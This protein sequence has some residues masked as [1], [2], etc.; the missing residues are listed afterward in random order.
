M[1]I[2][3]EMHRKR[4]YDGF[5]KLSWCFIITKSRFNPRLWRY[6][7]CVI[8]TWCEVIAV[9]WTRKEPEPSRHPRSISPKV[10]T[11]SP[12]ISGGRAQ[13]P[14]WCRHHG[15]ARTNSSPWEVCKPFQ[16]SIRC[17]F[18][19][20]RKVL[21][22]WNSTL[23]LVYLFNRYPASRYPCFRDAEQVTKSV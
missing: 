22:W 23:W 15:P 6:R 17:I 12:L 9:W 4:K 2:I 21:S 10:N 3:T 20:S 19:I 5:L 1:A 7:P 14:C 18:V 8:V 16:Y 13:S 11:I